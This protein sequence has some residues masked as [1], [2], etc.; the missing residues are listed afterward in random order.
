MKIRDQLVA[1]L[2]PFSGVLTP[3]TFKLLIDTEASIEHVF[4][5]F[6]ACDKTANMKFSQ[7]D[8]TLERGQQ[9]FKQRRK[10]NS[11]L[12]VIT[13]ASRN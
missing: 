5:Y 9:L 13:P 7:W 11:R 4:M 12:L 3:C 8:S 1:S 6:P 10:V 2:C